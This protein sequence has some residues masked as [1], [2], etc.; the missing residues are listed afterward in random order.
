MQTRYG[1]RPRWGPRHPCK[2]HWPADHREHY[3]ELAR[4][5]GL[6]LNE[7]VIRRLAE[8]H[9]LDGPRTGDDEQLPLG[10]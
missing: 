5:S 1:P 2:I 9:G 3:E 7:Y 8:A 6:S 10:A 4:K